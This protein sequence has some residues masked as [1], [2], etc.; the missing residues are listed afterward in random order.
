MAHWGR[1]Q[2]GCVLPE[3]VGPLSPPSLWDPPHPQTPMLANS[4]GA[5]Q[6][7]EG[8]SKELTQVAASRWPL[9]VPSPRG[10]AVEAGCF[11]T[12]LGTEVSLAPAQATLGLTGHNVSSVSDR[13]IAP[14]RSQLSG[15]PGRASAGSW[16]VG[17]CGQAGAAECPSDSK[18]LVGGGQ[19]METPAL[20]QKLE[21]RAYLYLHRL[22]F[23]LSEFLLGQVFHGTPSC[24]LLA[25]QGQGLNPWVLFC[26][27]P[28]G[29][30]RRQ[31]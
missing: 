24:G 27:G 8:Q 10:L 28:L 29:L 17:P 15:L 14:H 3:L 4:T 9:A 19:S 26:A 1:R 5:N 30:T 21:F 2:Q 7:D 25:L 31:P 12:R 20:T 6:R 18:L 22:V 23:L 16:P 11:V 13:K